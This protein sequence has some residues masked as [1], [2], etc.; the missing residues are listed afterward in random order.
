MDEKRILEIAKQQSNT[1]AVAQM[2]PEFLMRFAQ[3]VLNEYAPEH[4]I[5]S[6]EELPTDPGD[7]AI[8]LQ[9]HSLCPTQLSHL[10]RMRW[11][12]REFQ[13]RTTHAPV[14]PEA[15]LY[16]VRSG[17]SQGWEDCSQARYAAVGKAQEEPPKRFGPRWE[18]RILYRYPV[19][20]IDPDG[21]RFIWFFSDTSKPPEMINEYLQGV[22][23]HWTVDQWRAHVDKYMDKKDTP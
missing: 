16:Q 20:A 12:T 14:T 15:I 19:G 6:E 7:W 10:D 4:K 2:S 11:I 17:P 13:A 3:A 5:V 18:R 9:V 23:E 1:Q 8:M 21:P 22:R